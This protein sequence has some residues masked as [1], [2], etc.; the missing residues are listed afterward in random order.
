MSK[1]T[2]VP[3]DAMQSALNYQRM[4][5]KLGNKLIDLEVAVSKLHEDGVTVK[6]IKLKASPNPNGDWLAIV[7]ASTEN[8]EVVAFHSSDD[9]SSTI[10]GVGAKLRNGSLKW[11]E[12]EYA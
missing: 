3:G 5:L 7:T 1:S 6:M 2:D 12:D 9:L 11:K 4:V 10:T 8:G